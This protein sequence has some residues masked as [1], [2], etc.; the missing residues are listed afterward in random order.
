[1]TENNTFKWRP[2]YVGLL[3]AGMA[4]VLVTLGALQGHIPSTL[5]ALGGAFI[6]GAGGWGIVAWLIAATAQDV[7]ADIAE[8][9]T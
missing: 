6:I 1:M 5:W 4:T 9:D 7:E 2:I 3:F 8:E